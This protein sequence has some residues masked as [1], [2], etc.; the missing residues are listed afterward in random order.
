M[1]YLSP[2]SILSQN[3]YY[4]GNFNMKSI[5]P[6]KYKT[7]TPSSNQNSLRQQWFDMQVVMG[8]HTV[9]F[10]STGI[11]QGKAGGWEVTHS[12]KAGC[13]SCS[14]F[15][16]VVPHH[17]CHMNSVY[18]TQECD[19]TFKSQNQMLLPAMLREN[20]WELLKAVLCTC[21]PEHT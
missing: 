12:H 10:W 6:Y 20:F 4:V 21:G 1:L 17:T 8:H 19:Y 11:F 2:T 7:H 9:F 16:C 18:S 3:I 14:T 15:F 5:E 13:N